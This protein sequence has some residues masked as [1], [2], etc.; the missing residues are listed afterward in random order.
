MPN[1]TP[2][3]EQQMIEALKAS[4]RMVRH[5]K[6]V[7]AG[8]RLVRQ[9]QQVEAVCPGGSEAVTGVN[10]FDAQLAL[11]DGILALVGKGA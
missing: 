1:T 6:Q 7:E 11:L 10:P 3:T 8:L 4:L 9:Q 2:Q 5:R